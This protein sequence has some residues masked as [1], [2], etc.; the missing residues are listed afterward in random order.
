M[1]GVEAR[2]KDLGYNFA[3]LDKT[4]ID[5]LLKQLH[6]W[7]EKHPEWAN[8]TKD[9]EDKINE[10]WPVLK[11]KMEPGTEDVP[12][13]LNDWQQQMQDWLD[14]HGSKLK[15]KPDM[16]RDDIVKMVHQSVKDTQEIVDQTKPILLRFGVDLSNIPEELP[17][18]LRTPWGKKQ[19]ADYPVA[20]KENQTDKDFLKEFGLPNPKEKGSGRKEDKEL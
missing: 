14:K 9:I 8:I 19:A 5:N 10:H 4:Q 2:M 17:V 13:K 16:T 20:A 1:E 3:K 11:F 15:I 6:D 12:K 18:G 7:I